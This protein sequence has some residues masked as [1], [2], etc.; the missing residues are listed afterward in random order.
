VEGWGGTWQNNPE[1]NPDTGVCLSRLRVL[2]NK[3][4]T[5]KN[6]SKEAQNKVC[7]HAFGHVKA[8]K[9]GEGHGQ[10]MCEVWCKES[11]CERHTT[12][13]S[14][15]QEMRQLTKEKEKNEQKK[16]LENKNKISHFFATMAPL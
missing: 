1:A 2:E 11:K 16:P 15:G 12:K 13:G 4:Q 14:D 6:V 7:S 9:G 8:W 3:A 5:R 10:G